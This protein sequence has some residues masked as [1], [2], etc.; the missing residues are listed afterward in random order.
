MLY[1][2]KHEAIEKILKKYTKLWG[3]L[4]FI[5]IAL[6]IWTAPVSCVPVCDIYSKEYAV[7]VTSRLNRAKQKTKLVAIVFVMVKWNGSLKYRD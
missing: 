4:S 5:F 3:S 6:E 1:E 7:W 2:E